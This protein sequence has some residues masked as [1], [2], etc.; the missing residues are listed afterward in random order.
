MVYAQPKIRPGKWDAYTFLGFWD[1]NGPPDHD[2]I[3][4]PSDSKKKK[5]KSNKKSKKNE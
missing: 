1:T 4:R 2:Q 5:K 3:T